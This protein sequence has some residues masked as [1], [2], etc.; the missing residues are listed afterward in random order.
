MG[1]PL[2]HTTVSAP[3][4]P[5][6]PQPPHPTAPGRPLPATLRIHRTPSRHHRTTRCQPGRCPLAQCP[7]AQCPLAQCLLSR[8]GECRSHL[9]PRGTSG[10]RRRGRGPAFRHPRPI[11]TPRRPDRPSRHH[12]A[13]A[14]RRPWRRHPPAIPRLPLAT[15]PRIPASPRC[16]AV[17]RR[18]HRGRRRYR[19]RPGPAPRRRGQ[20]PAR[21]RRCPAARHRPRPGRILDPSRRPAPSRDRGALCHPEVPRREALAHR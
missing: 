2:A 8:C 20:A 12:R 9:P 13:P 17:I 11:R 19:H 15:P 3:A 18:R 6:P 21:H 7:P 16:I 1:Q 5:L 4:R 10:N 14:R